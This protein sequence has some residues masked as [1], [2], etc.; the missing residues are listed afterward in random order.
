MAAELPLDL[1]QARDCGLGCQRCS[2]RHQ[3]VS[4]VPGSLP[5]PSRGSSGTTRRRQP[6]RVI[7]DVRGE[8]SALTLWS[9]GR[10]AMAPAAAGNARTGRALGSPVP[11][12][13]GWVTMIDGIPAA[14]VLLGP[15]LNAVPGWWWAIGGWL[16][17]GLLCGPRG[18]GE[19]SSQAAEA[20]CVPGVLIWLL[21]LEPLP[22]LVRAA[23]GTSGYRGND[24]Q[25]DAHGD[26]EVSAGVMVDLPVG[27]VAGEERGQ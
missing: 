23:T 5:D 19:S 6:L 25:D 2:S 22:R 12:I 8:A 10:A 21:R 11:R 18:P 13:A 15:V 3:Q 16:C 14:A 7:G 4:P 1:S 20:A 27:G 24:Q 26:G 9:A 17:A